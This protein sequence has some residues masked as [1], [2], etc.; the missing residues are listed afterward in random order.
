M[1]NQIEISVADL[2]D[3]VEAARFLEILRGDEDGFQFKAENSDGVEF[4]WVTKRGS[5]LWLA[6]EKDIVEFLA[7]CGIS[8]KTD[9][10]S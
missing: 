2:N 4:G 10:K 8:I 1:P 3:I 5:P 9:A 7:E 6:L